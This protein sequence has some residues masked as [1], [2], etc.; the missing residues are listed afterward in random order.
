VKGGREIGGEK[1]SKDR[2]LNHVQITIHFRL[3]SKVR[4]GRN[5]TAMIS[6]DVLLNG[7]ADL[8][9]DCSRGRKPVGFLE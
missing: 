5:D 9:P 1:V 4:N 3:L 7:D 2:N 6:L 8:R